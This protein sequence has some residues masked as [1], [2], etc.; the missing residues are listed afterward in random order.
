MADEPQ[1]LFLTAFPPEVATAYQE[2]LIADQYPV[3]EHD[4]LLRLFKAILDHLWLLLRS[5]YC[6]YR[7]TRGPI[8]EIE[9]L[10]DSLREKKPKSW[11]DYQQLV[12]GVWKNLESEIITIK[13]KG[14][15]NTEVR[16]SIACFI[17]SWRA[18]REC[19][20]THRHNVTGLH[21]ETVV[22]PLVTLE[23][24]KNS[25]WEMFD[26]VIQCRNTKAH[27]DEYVVK[28]GEPSINLHLGSPYY[29]FIN[30]SLREALVELLLELRPAFEDYQIG[31]IPADAPT[32]SV[33]VHYGRLMLPKPVAP[34][35]RGTFER[36]TKWL[37]HSGTQA[38]FRLVE[39][40][41]VPDPFVAAVEIV[42][43]E[44]S[45]DSRAQEREGQ[46][47]V[48]GPVVVPSPPT[49]DVGAAVS[50]PTAAR[51]GDTAALGYGLLLK[52]YGGRATAVEQL[53]QAEMQAILFETPLVRFLRRLGDLETPRHVF[54]TGNAGDGKSFAVV[55]ASL[56]PGE[57]QV[58]LDASESLGTGDTGD[59]ISALASEFDRHLAAGK[60]LLVA[61]NRGQLERLSDY[62]RR[63]REA[64][65][66]TRKVVESASSQTRLRVRWD[67]QHEVVGLID[68]GH[69]DAL[70][71]EVIAALL[72]KAA[73]ATLPGEGVSNSTR[74]IFEAARRA[75]MDGNVAKNVC[76]VLQSLDGRGRHV[77]L[78]Q[79]WQ[80]VAYLATGARRVN[81]I[82]PARIADSVGARLFS[83]KAK[84]ALFESIMACDPMLVPQPG[85]AREALEAD[86]SEKLSRRP[87]LAPL[88]EE[89]LDEVHDGPALIRAAC[90]HGHGTAE[91]PTFPKSPY[92]KLVRELRQRDGAV[93]WHSISGLSPQLFRG[94]YRCLGYWQSAHLLPAWQRLCYDSTRFEDRV[95][96]AVAVA[97]INAESLRFALPKPPPLAVEA[98][99]ESWQPPYVLMA[100]VT[101]NKEPHEAN[102]LRL[103]PRLFRSLHDESAGDASL[104][105]EEGLVVARWLAGLSPSAESDDGVW[106]SQGGTDR[107][108]R[109]AEA[110]LDPGRWR[111]QWES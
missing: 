110:S 75:L 44:V 63:G 3:A 39:N 83:E 9:R 85:L 23:R 62:L 28:P 54:L 18:M 89:G 21:Y 36:D 109:L 74:E 6:D 11:G 71:D 104:S 67:S 26:A 111:I 60:R 76:H 49:T 103:T 107:A 46:V 78:R 61:I 56:D 15:R 40:P 98:L 51:V 48:V 57:F 47:S 95:D 73:S 19:W 108:L 43:A 25:L 88:L 59:P 69:F 99:G 8:P 58:V 96:A 90:L 79:L 22:P 12:N 30:K 42:N 24:G 17:A 64:S 32:I 4:A 106:V 13:A 65:D 53:T 70:S 16:P 1:H 94:V 91:W 93:A 87:G 86:L 55:A 10:L 34:P 102:S 5:E 84:G 20:L 27:E 45:A 37:V 52:L 68:L 66:P 100:P 41:K 7:E 97:R 35:A 29:R 101:S 105:A 80:V 72:Q 33:N 50:A 2:L 92:R 82:S 77:T 14:H 31:E 81:D 38:V